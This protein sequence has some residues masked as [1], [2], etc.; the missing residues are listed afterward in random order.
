MSLEQ[1]TQLFTQIADEI[2]VKGIF[3]KVG[4]TERGPIE[5]RFFRDAP[6][7]VGFIGDDRIEKETLIKLMPLVWAGH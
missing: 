2:N 6:T 1:Y 7:L 3:I 4:D 5:I